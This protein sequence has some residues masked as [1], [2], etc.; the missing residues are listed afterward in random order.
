MPKLK[1]P[2]PIK[3]KI[4]TTTIIIV[5]TVVIIRFI[6]DNRSSERSYRRK[7]WRLYGREQGATVA[8]L[9]LA[10]FFICKNARA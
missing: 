8:G 10:S 4:V 5:I 7:Q 2:C 9:K 6:S 1:P 3:T